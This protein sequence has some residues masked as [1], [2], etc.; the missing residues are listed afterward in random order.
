MSINVIKCNTTNLTKAGTSDPL[1]M[2]QSKTK[3][4]IRR[5]Q[6]RAGKLW[7][8]YLQSFNYRMTESITLTKR[9]SSPIEVPPFI[10]AQGCVGEYVRQLWFSLTYCS[11]L[12]QPFHSI[13]NFN[14]GWL[15]CWQWNDFF[16]SFR[17]CL[18]SFRRTRCLRASR[19]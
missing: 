19:G 18:L 8:V 15:S 13:F 5:K 1:I 10:L 11:L 12:S 9:D 14:L 4:K 17:C 7:L 3:Q 6:N 16:R 2:F